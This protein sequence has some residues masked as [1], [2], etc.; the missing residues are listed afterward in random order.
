MQLVYF[1]HSYRQDDQR[2][3]DFFSRLMESEQ[4]I[5][6]L[7]PPSETVN[8]AKLQRH[9]NSSDG[10]VAV[11]TERD[12]GPSPYILFE[13]E[14]CLRSRKPLLV[15][16]EDVLPDG[17]VPARILQRRFSRSAFL[18][19]VR[20]HRHALT[21]FRSYV[22]DDPA[23]R[24]QPQVSQRS[25]VISG[26]ASLPSS[27]ADALKLSVAHRGYRVV[28]P[29]AH[30]EIGAI[31][32]LA[33]AD[34]AL[35]V[36]DDT[37]PVTQYARGLLQGASVPTIELTTD[38]AEEE[39]GRA[40]PDE[41]RP[42]DVTPP[43]EDSNVPIRLVETQLSVAEED[44]LELPDQVKVDSYFQILVDLGSRHGHYSGADQERIVSLVMGDQYTV[45][46]AGAVGPGSHAENMT[47]VQAWND[48]SELGD[49]RTLAD[50]LG[51]LRSRLRGD[52]KEPEHDVVVAALAEAEME[53]KQ[54]NGPAALERLS[55][56][57][58]VAGAT[59]WAL[60][61]ATS[62]GT[63]LAAAA[64]KAVLGL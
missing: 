32:T 7:D 55:G 45:G 20:E 53:A 29:T 21:V 39:S 36:V 5:L 63:T 15:F 47:F 35:V 13:I 54:G 43:H 9:L 42:L 12:G 49:T 61:A 48:L 34:L 64:L 1:S 26:D 4:L 44:F 19:Q 2:V 56:L 51:Q 50:E 41:F 59:K 37:S 3:N 22:G 18:R 60:D 10:M 38:A 16:L 24:Y 52:A 46:Q 57:R 11:I 58:R 28:G 6:S 62:I 23:P 17:L 40:I 31:E 30:E 33:Q 25:C 27:L 14:L 8:T